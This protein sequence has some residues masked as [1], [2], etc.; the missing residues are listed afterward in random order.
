[1]I[2]F[3]ILQFYFIFILYLNCRE[4]RVGVDVDIHVTSSHLWHTCTHSHKMMSTKTALNSTG[5]I[6][7]RIEL[8]ESNWRNYCIFFT[9]TRAWFIIL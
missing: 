1:V 8:Y 9:V 2:L 6:G 4:V 3:F 7:R 5:T